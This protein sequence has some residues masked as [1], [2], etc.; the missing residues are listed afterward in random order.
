M[1]E[2]EAAAIAAEAKAQAEAAAAEAAND[3][4]VGPENWAVENGT[5]TIACQDLEA[6]PDDLASRFGADTKVLDLSFNSITTLDHLEGFGKIETL[7][8][9]NNALTSAQPGLAA[10]AGSLRVLS[11]NNNNID[12]L[13]A[14]LDSLA[15]LQS[16]RILSMLKNPACP[17]MFFG[18]DSEDY[19]RHRLYVIHKL[20]KLE[21]LDT[22][23]VTAKER[24]E[25]IRR[26]AFLK[27]AKPEAQ[28]AASD[29][30]DAAADR[31][32][33]DSDDLPGLNQQMTAPGRSGPAKY[34][35]CSYVYYGKQS[36][37]NRFILNEDL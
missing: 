36:E 16:L 31:P 8:A 5:L 2:S 32:S 22:Q 7:V 3:P 34:G 29:D 15:P 19:A 30:A 14:F 25:A 18:G 13:D 26:G 6:I 23:P 28:P 37:G 1:S 11:V 12:D 20:R 21:L 24:A 4:V 33:N 10:L 9:D 27:T 35:V 17:S